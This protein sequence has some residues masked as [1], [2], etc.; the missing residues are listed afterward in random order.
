MSR[1][2]ASAAADQKAG[3]WQNIKE[4]FG[5]DGGDPG[6][7]NFSPEWWGNQGGAWGQN[8]GTIVF[9]AKSPINGSV[10]VTSH[11]ASSLSRN[12]SLPAAHEEWRVLRFNDLTRQ[13]AARVSVSTDGS[14]TQEPRC[15]AQEYLKSMVAAGA[16]LLGRRKEGIAVATSKLRILCIGVGGGSLPLFLAHHFPSADVEGVEVDPVVVEAARDHM[17]FSEANLP[18]LRITID[19]AMVFMRNHAREGCEPYDLVFMDAF[20]GTDETPNELCGQEF[21]KLLAGALDP[22]HGALVMNVHGRKEVGPTEEYYKAMRE[23]VQDAE[24]LPKSAV[25][26]TLECAAQPNTVLICSYGLDM[27]DDPPTAESVLGS[28]AAEIA[29]SARFT[30]R[31][32]RRASHKYRRV[33]MQENGVITYMM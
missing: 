4:W 18:N 30:F 20:D 32:R 7:W 17:G 21:G 10:I 1:I 25:C 8:E 23:A 5:D 13:S 6:H 24:R 27:P 33:L 19:D 12:E 31:V 3:F 16:A 9:Q 29:E 14:L 11:E 22:S 28:S 2:V 15:L 26:F